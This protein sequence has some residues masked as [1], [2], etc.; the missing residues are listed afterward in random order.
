MITATDPTLQDSAAQP[1]SRILV[2]DIRNA[3]AP[4]LTGIEILR[5]RGAVGDQLT[6]LEIMTAQVRL[7]TTIL[8]HHSG[9]TSG[10]LDTSGGAT[11]GSGPI[12][13]ESVEPETKT[14]LVV[15][16]NPNIIAALKMMFEDGRYIVLAATKAEDAV[17]LA[18]QFKPDVCLCDI[19]L[20]TMDGFAA[21]AELSRAHPSMRL[22]SM[23]GLDDLN[24]RK[25]SLDAGFR[26]HFK[27]P[28]P[29]EEIIR[30]FDRTD[31]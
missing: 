15:D 12:I 16:D 25:Q 14:V 11:E 23:S 20:P 22:F 29:F 27:K 19:S 8:D 10:D 18:I 31:A 1:D 26:A 28:V 30:V 21:A 13:P 6:V 17:G 3:L 2:H 4:L 9:G 7:L 5:G 24:I